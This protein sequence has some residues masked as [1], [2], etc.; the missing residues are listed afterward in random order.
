MTPE[1]AIEI[2]QDLWRYEKVEY[3]DKEIREAIE[4]AVEALQKLKTGKWIFDGCKDICS[5][6]GASREHQLWDEYCGR[7]GLKMEAN[8]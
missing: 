2:L 4:M 6:C 7:C 3:T 5:E 1:K 8:E